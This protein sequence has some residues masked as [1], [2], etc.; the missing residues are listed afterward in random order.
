MVNR[1]YKDSWLDLKPYDKIV[2]TDYYYLNLCNE[3]KDMIVYGGNFDELVSYLEEEDIDYLSCLLTS[4]F[5]DIISGSNIW[6]TFV[7]I[8][9]RMYGKFLPFYDTDVYYEEEINSQ[10]ISFLIWYFL[11]II[12][13]EMLVSPYHGFILVIAESVME[14]FDNAWD[15]APENEVLKTYY[16]ME[17]NED[18]YYTAREMISKILFETYLFHPDTQRRLVEEEKELDEKMEDKENILL[19]LREAQDDFLHSAHTRLFNLKGKEW[20][21][22][23]LGDEHP[24]SRDFRN[25]SPRIAGLFLYKGQ[26]EKDVFVEHIASGMRFNMTQKSFEANSIKDIDTIL[27]LGLVRWKEEWWFSGISFQAPYNANVVMKEKKSAKT[28]RAVDFL[29]IDKKKTEEVLKDQL[30]A[31]K[32]VNNGEQIVF[33]PR[34]KVNEFIDKFIEKYNE[35]LDI[36]EEEKKDAMRRTK[37]NELLGKEDMAEVETVL[38]F[39]NPFS[40]LEI[41]SGVEH[42]FPL[43]N[44]PYFDEDKSQDDVVSLLSSDMFS[45]E[46]AMYCIDHC[47]ED[48]PFFKNELGLLYLDDIDFLLR[49]WKKTNYFATPTITLASDKTDSK[50]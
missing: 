21:A 4:Y 40:G 15:D 10:D 45:K 50:R 44:N 20:A 31:F 36:P 22:E 25:M 11:N 23:I 39:F 47:K 7:K 41:A 42:A 29:T 30:E 35:L 48:L 38:I 19:Y 28:K 12:Q 32:M 18:N 6:N 24:L 37:R 9:K 17:E 26:D 2:A 1:I 34:D 14:L 5:E 27:Y 16:Q 8:H 43:S 33:L 3:V 49:F 13:D 46:L